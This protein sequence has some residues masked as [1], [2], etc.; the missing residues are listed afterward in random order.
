MTQL[1]YIKEI[2]KSGLENDQEKFKEA[3]N[4]LIEHAKKTKKINYALQ[5]QSLLKDAIRQEQSKGPKL[6]GSHSYFTR[7]EDRELN[8]FVLEKIT[9]EYRFDNLIV[10]KEIQE[11]LE[12]LVDEH[13]SKELIQKF[14]LPISNKVLFYGP[15]GCGKTL[16]SYVIAGELEKM[17]YVINLGAIVSSKLGETSKNLAKVFRQAATEDC[18]I[19]IDEFD[20]LGKVRDYAQ[21][22]GEMKRIVNTILQLFDYLPQNSIVVAATNQIEMID[23]A[24]LRRFDVKLRLDLPNKTQIKKLIEL[25]L[26]NGKFVFDRK[27]AVSSILK[28]AE[29]LSYYII[30]KALIG[31]IKRSILDRDFIDNQ[32]IVK[33]STSTWLELIQQEKEKPTN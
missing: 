19:F 30:Q 25:V 28:N 21:D 33:I 12:F 8:D 4:E 7:F 32:N 22:H 18:I 31:A 1:S 9:S 23:N 15:S 29:G 13:K 17:M 11:Q 2:V 27:N 24:L 16:A 20:S 10:S 3:L 5:L 6:I 26:K 14:N